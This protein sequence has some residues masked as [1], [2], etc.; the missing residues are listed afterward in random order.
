[1]VGPKEYDEMYGARKFSFVYSRCLFII[2]D[3]D[4]LNDKPY[5]AYIE[6]VLKEKRQE[7]EHAFVFLHVPPIALRG[8]PESRT[9]PEKDELF[10]ILKEY[11][12][13]TAFFGDFHGYWRG[14]VNGVDVVVTGGGGSRLQGDTTYGFH[15]LVVISVDKDGASERIISIPTV[16][17]LEDKIEELCFRLL[18]PV[19]GVS[20]TMYY[21][22]GGL[23]F[24]AGAGMGLMM[25]RA[26]LR[27]RR[28][29]RRP[30]ASAH[31]EA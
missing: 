14:K 18:F 22:V 11:N 9:T 16:N 15:H 23:I 31:I 7:C 10:R 24:L 2:S 3:F 27:K 1:M 25:I 17:S 26:R 5:T 29:L 19:F 8:A 13:D 28:A 21:G 20:Q 30:S 12:V 4:A 6:G